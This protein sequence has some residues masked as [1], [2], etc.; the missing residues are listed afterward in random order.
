MCL[1][2]PRLIRNT[3]EFRCDAGY[4]DL[5]T[6]RR[7]SPKLLDDTSLINAQPD[8]IRDRPSDNLA[9]VLSQYTSFMVQFQLTITTTHATKDYQVQSHDRVEVNISRPRTSARISSELQ[10]MLDL[11][12]GPIPHSNFALTQPAFDGLERPCIFCLYPNM[13]NSPDIP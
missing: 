7:L 3:R 5:Y 10:T 13:F 12:S 4:L 1:L 9:S 6:Q 11:V 8:R 2:K